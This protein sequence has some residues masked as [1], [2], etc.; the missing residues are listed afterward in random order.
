MHNENLIFLFLNKNICCGYS[1]EPSQWDG[2]FEHPKHMLK[3]MGKKIY[4]ILRWNFLFILTCPVNMVNY[5]IPLA[6]GMQYK[7][8]MIQ[9]K[10]VTNSHIGFMT[11]RL[12]PHGGHLVP[13]PVIVIPS[14]HIPRWVFWIDEG[15]VPSL[16]FQPLLGFYWKREGFHKGPG[17]WW[18]LYGWHNES[19][20]HHLKKKKKTMCTKLNVFYVIC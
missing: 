13:S 17:M 8:L 3:L 20:L 14:H 9:I 6:K 2:S 7:F 19:S 16:E 11:Q 15:G 4:T 1:K 18:V 10:G 5:L 12:E